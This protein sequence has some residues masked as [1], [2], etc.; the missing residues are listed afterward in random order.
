MAK[1]AKRNRADS[2]STGVPDSI[3]VSSNDRAS[4]DL[5]HNS[6]VVGVGQDGLNQTDSSV[7]CSGNRGSDHGGSDRGGSDRGGSGHCGS[8]HGCSCRGVSGQGYSGRG[9]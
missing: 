2:S 6:D 7:G 3:G 9:G 1:R 8:V 4:Y 5:R